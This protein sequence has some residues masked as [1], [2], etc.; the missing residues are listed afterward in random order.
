MIRKATEADIEDLVE[1][2]ASFHAAAKHP[3][4]YN[5]EH[6]RD[7]LEAM[8]KQGA[9]FRSDKGMIGGLLSPAYCNRNWLMAVELFWW[10][11]DRQGLKLLRAFERWAKDVGADEV[12]MTTLASH[13]DVETIISRMG[14]APAEISHVK[15]L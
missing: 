9:V 13:P 11:E 1:M 15:V 12:R 10:S 5:P 14:Y 7:L 2:G 3:S 6:A 8:F 4:R